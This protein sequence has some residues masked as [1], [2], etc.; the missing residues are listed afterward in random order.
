[1]SS[2]NSDYGQ[3]YF[4]VIWGDTI[5]HFQEV[6][7][8]DTEVQII[9]DEHG[10]SKSFYPIKMPG[11]GKVGNVMFRR[12]NFVG[13]TYW[14]WYNK[15]QLNSMARINI[16]IQLVNE[17]NQSTMEWV[18]NNAWPT[19][20]TSTDMNS[21]GDSAAIDSIEIAYETLVIKNQNNI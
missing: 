14:D 3:F 20:I 21:S 15:I 9:K 4:K 8:L 17:N 19:K 12:G 16:T 18:L 13:S 6:T 5:I 7:G 11:I 2:W 1:M 10:N